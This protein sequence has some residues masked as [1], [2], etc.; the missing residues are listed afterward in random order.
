M[1]QKFLTVAGIFGS[2]DIGSF[3]GLESPQGYIS[4]V[5]NRG[6]NQNEVSHL[7]TLSFARL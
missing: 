4:Q 2:D 6:R 7:T 3:E 1:T 5:A